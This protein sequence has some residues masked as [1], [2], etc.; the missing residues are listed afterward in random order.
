MPT[1][2]PP[3]TKPPR[4]LVIVLAVLAVL[5]AS[6]N[7]LAKAALVAGMQAV[8]G[9]KVDVDVMDVGLLNTAL[10][11]KGLRVRNPAGFTEPILLDIPEVY[12]DY[13]VLPFLKGK[14]HLERVRVNMK[15]MVVVK[16]A[17]GTV[18]VKQ[19]KALETA[20]GKKAA[21]KAQPKPAAKAPPM[22]LE[23]DLLEMKIGTVIYKD[24]SKGSPP[25]I[26]EFTVNIDQRYEH[27]RDP[28]TFVGVVVAAALLNTTV[29][30]LAGV[31]VAKIHAEAQRA[32][33]QSARELNRAFSAEGGKAFEKSANE[34]KR[35]FNR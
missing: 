19:I 9:L 8:T 24:Y 14:T 20:K 34:L 29:G 1:R 28:A 10:G 30:Q 31:D 4:A 27:I 15:E 11:I 18:N 5:Y 17:D 3:A 26:K 16:L 35:L 6:K 23:I 25:R 22:N 33:L 21:P 13:K 12:V 32:M 7:L 2:K